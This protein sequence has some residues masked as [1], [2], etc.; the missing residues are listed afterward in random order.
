M[1]ITANLFT[2][3]RLSILEPINNGV[4]MK[5]ISLSSCI[6]I[7]LLLLSI[8]ACKKE[9]T[10]VPVPLTPDP[11]APTPGVIDKTGGFNIKV[12]PPS[13]AN[14]YIHRKNDFD[15]L[16]VVKSDETNNTEKDIECIIEAE[17]LEAK[18]HGI[19]MVANI[20]PEMCRY[21]T[22]TPFYYF[23][24]PYGSADGAEVTLNYNADGV[25]QSGSSTDPNIQITAGG[26]PRCVFDHTKR[27]GPNCC[28]GEIT[29]KTITD[30]GP[31]TIENRFVGGM[32]GNCVAGPGM[33]MPRSSSNGM[34]MSTITFVKDGASVEFEVEPTISMA[35]SEAYFYANYRLPATPLPMAWM[36]GSHHYYRWTCYDDAKEV[37][38]RISVQIRDWNE[39]SE[40]L[41]KGL[42][43]PDTGGTEP[44]WGTEYNDYWDW[45]DIVSNGDG[46]PGMPK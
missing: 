32:P 28:T 38:A 22:Y 4:F 26:E 16:C 19:K 21:F 25:F 45:D 27:D 36:V 12:N 37:K 43:D 30:G 13:G 18:Y 14:Y 7:T 20:P 2:A 11:A 1:L 42:G 41:L 46:F 23:G 24:L 3:Q 29:L 17:E 33:R 6:G 8:T 15:K 40:F 31:A 5:R 34:P 35:N 44:F 10:V 9:E 39:M